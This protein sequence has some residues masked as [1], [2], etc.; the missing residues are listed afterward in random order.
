MKDCKEKN[1]PNKKFGSI[2]QTNELFDIEQNFDV[3]S[4]RISS[5]FVWPLVRHTFYYQILK[6]NI[7]FS[8]KFR[9]TSKVQL[10]KNGLYGVKNLLRIKKFDYLFFNNADKRNLV[11]D[12]K[13][14]DVFFDAWAD[15][16]GQDRSL[17]VE[18]AIEKHWRS[19]EVY[20]KYVISDLFIKLG[21]FLFTL[22]TKGRMS[23]LEALEKVKREYQLQIDIKKEVSSMYGKIRF[24]RFLLRLIR[25]R[26]I[27]LI[28]SFTKMDLVVAA[29]LENV[30]VYEAQH[31]YI[32]E[33]HQFYLAYLNFGSLY[34]PDFLI[35]FGNWEKHASVDHFIFKQQQIIPVGSLYLEHVQSNVKNKYL[36]ELKESYTKIFCVT[37]QT[38]EETPLLDFI[39]KEALKN[40]EWL[41]ILKPR[42][43]NHLDY[44]KY[45]Q[46]ENVVLFP[47]YS[48]YEILKYS[49]YNITIYSTTA[50]EAEMFGVKTLFYN[51]AGL[52]EKYFNVKKMFASIVDAE[53]GIEKEALMGAHSF[54]PY[55]KMGYHENVNN[56]DLS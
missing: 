24:Y 31:G 17:F 25:P 37:L 27:F 47:D 41:F 18:W 46:V 55:F 10:I 30:K 1:E 53:R 5:L 50:V 9:T 22:F 23:T 14:Y 12:K 44:S 49:D 15:K 28:S 36:A 35:A 54:I 32:G 40:K 6:K 56:T 26:A 8:S 19:N 42:N 20:S 16:L 13:K 7:G 3:G 21:C 34:Y 48:V 45:T 29:H 51:I 38:V 52:S 4:A 2:K 33:N 43:F 39:M 11:V